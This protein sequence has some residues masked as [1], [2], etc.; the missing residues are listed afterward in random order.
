MA[1]DPVKGSNSYLHANITDASTVCYTRQKYQSQA[2]TSSILKRQPRLSGTPPAAQQRNNTPPTAIGAVPGPLEF[3]KYL[4][5]KYPHLVTDEITMVLKQHNS[6]AI[7]HLTKAS[8][9]IQQALLEAKNGLQMDTYKLSDKVINSPATRCVCCRAR[10][11][12]D[13]PAAASANSKAVRFNTRVAHRIHGQ[14]LELSDNEATSPGPNPK[15]PHNTRGF[16]DCPASASANSK[17][18]CFSTP[19][20]QRIHGQ[21]L[22]LSDDEATSPGLKRKRPHNVDDCTSVS[23]K[24]SSGASG[25][26][27]NFFKT[28]LM[29]IAQ[30]YADLPAN[31]PATVFGQC[32]TNLQKRKYVFQHGFATDPWG[33]GV[34]QHPRMVQP[35]T[36]LLPIYRSCLNKIFRGTTLSTPALGLYAS[37]CWL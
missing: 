25:G 24:S 12:N 14:R 11:F 26:L 28:N 8:N 17:S 23:K 21:R 37:L 1:L 9:S 22:E 15:R 35:Q 13:Y 29:A 2:P 3:A 4:R 18:V 34:V 36:S 31:T 32:C 20:A 19:V 27:F 16:N 10:G 33:K 5:E 6:R 30:L 7:M